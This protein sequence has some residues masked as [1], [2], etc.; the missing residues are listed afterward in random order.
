MRFLRRTFSETRM[1]LALLL[2]MFLL[3]IVLDDLNVPEVPPKKRRG[4]KGL[5][6]FG[7]DMD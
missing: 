7:M 5:P 6:S 4:G 1:S 2:L 3:R